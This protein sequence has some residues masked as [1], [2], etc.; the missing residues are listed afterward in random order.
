MIVLNLKLFFRNPFFFLSSVKCFE[1]RCMIL[2]SKFV[3]L[4]WNLQVIIDY[5]YA[6]YSFILVPK[7]ILQYIARVNGLIFLLQ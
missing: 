3:M 2:A 4:H 1:Q 6:L 5:L 7:L